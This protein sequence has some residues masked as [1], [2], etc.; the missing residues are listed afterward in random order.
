MAYMAVHDWSRRWEAFLHLGHALL[1][2]PPGSGLARPHE[3]AR[4]PA[5][6]AGALAVGH[7]PFQ[8]MNE[9]AEI[10]VQGLAWRESR[11]TRPASG[12][13]GIRR[14]TSTA[15]EGLVVHKSRQASKSQQGQI[16]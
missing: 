6:P 4:R 9:A 3:H 8:R 14:A 5:V 16:V 12:V 1:G 11:P 7:F 10:R 15:A 2:I 13:V